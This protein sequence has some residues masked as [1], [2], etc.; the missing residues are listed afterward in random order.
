MA[1]EFNFFD[2]TNDD[3]A[4]KVFF[5]FQNSLTLKYGVNPHQWAKLYKNDY[6][7]D[8][9]NLYDHE[10]SYNDFL[11]IDSALTISSEFFDVNCCVFV[12][13]SSPCS[14]ALGKNLKDAFEKAIDSDPISVINATVAFT[15]KIDDVVAK[16][17]SKIEF[18]III[19]PD[20]SDSALKILSSNQNCKL[21]RI[22]TAIKDY[23]N[24]LKNDIKVTPLGVLIQN[25]N[26][27]DLMK[28][29]FK[30]VSKMKPTQEI[31]EDLIFAWKIAKHTKSSSVVIAKDFKTLAI[32]QGQTNSLEVIEYALDKACDGAKD[33]V[34]ATDGTLQTQKNIFAIAQARVKAIIETGGSTKDKDVIDAANKYEIVIITT[35]I[36]QY[37]H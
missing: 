6:C 12:K 2:L 32:V 4:N 9:D 37:K 23:K 22:K 36:R 35:G 24:F 26:K 29:S 31:A 30:V 20:F 33:A 15:Q 7:I 3:D 17:L 18:N 25:S 8:Y 34:L 10:L 1:T 21:I 27:T 5:D 14:V 28:D 16:S 19:A 11:D 13:H